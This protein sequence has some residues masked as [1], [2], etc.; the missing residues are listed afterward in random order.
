MTAI[1]EEYKKIKS[2]YEA[3]FIGI[4]QCP[5]EKD[6]KHCPVEERLIEAQRL[7]FRKGLPVGW[8]H[9]AICNKKLGPEKHAWM[10]TNTTC[11]HFDIQAF[12]GC[13]GCV[14]RQT[15]KKQQKLLKSYVY[16]MH[17]SI[18]IK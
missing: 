14:S 5:D 1:F 6:M 3:S 7:R 11:T 13:D 18:I 15:Q 4:P 16:L 9:C 2:E 8:V 10:C 17:D 12:F